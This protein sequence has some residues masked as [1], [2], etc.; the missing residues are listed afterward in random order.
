M[1]FLTCALVTRLPVSNSLQK[2]RS[3]AHTSFSL[4][5]LC[6]TFILG[7]LIIFTSYALEPTMSFLYKWR[8]YQPYA[9]LEW[10]SNTNLQLHRL[11]HEELGLVEW[12]RCTKEVP[13]TQPDVLLA[14][15]DIINPE[16][17]VLSREEMNK[18]EKP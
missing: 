18:L 1:I 5:G 2:I 10:I 16:R 12:S 6:F 14:S 17:P 9:Q 11:A 15:L 13:T 8:N 4:F 3:A 7:G